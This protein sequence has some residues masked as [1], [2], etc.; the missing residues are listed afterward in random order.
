MAESSVTDWLTLLV[1]AGGAAAALWQ[2]RIN[3]I[4]S[5]REKK[6]LYAVKAADEMEQF[7]QSQDV[8]TA[9]RVVDWDSGYI[10]LPGA[11]NVPTKI[12]HGPQEF[13]L[14]LRHHTVARSQIP[15]YIAE[16]DAYACKR[17]KEGREYEEFFS[18]EEQS[19]RDIFDAFLTRLE[20]IET[21]I[22]YDVI[23]K[24]IFEEH[25]SYWLRVLA[26][27]K[28]FDGE[29]TFANPHKHACLWSYIRMYRFNG[30]VRLFELYGLARDAR[31]PWYRKSQ[32]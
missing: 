25:F 16:K 19:L 6:R 5:Q 20:R 26:E 31:A 17:K 24:E 15:D 13:C 4:A 11:G 18:P 14:A 10:L 32:L 22:R 30:V 1:S 3:S 21:L 2:Y 28:K 23:S 27:N 12:Y 29:M 8:R 9:L 7:H